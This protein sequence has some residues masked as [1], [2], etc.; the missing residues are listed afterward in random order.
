MIKTT[1]RPATET[2]TVAAIARMID[3]RGRL[4]F[5][6]WVR[7]CLDRRTWSGVRHVQYTKAKVDATTRTVLTG[8]FKGERLTATVA[9]RPG[10]CPDVTFDIRC[11][12]LK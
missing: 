5:R 11:E 3:H 4:R 12:G 2:E 8:L 7:E 10:E 1:F 6:H 9:E